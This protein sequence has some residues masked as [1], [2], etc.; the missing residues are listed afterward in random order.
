MSKKFKNL[1]QNIKSNFSNVI[2]F[3]DLIKYVNDR[4]ISDKKIE[5]LKDALYIAK[6][7]L[8][9][10]E[11]LNCIKNDDILIADLNFTR[12]ELRINIGRK[13]D[14]INKIVTQLSNLAHR[15][16]VNVPVYNNMLKML[17][18]SKIN[19][20]DYKHCIIGFNNE[21]ISTI[22]LLDTDKNVL[23]KEMFIK[24]EKDN[25][26]SHFLVSKIIKKYKKTMYDIWASTPF[27]SKGK[28]FT[29][30]PHKKVSDEELE[31]Q[32]NF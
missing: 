13:L 31:I 17:K 29:N 3:N 27:N 21:V 11:K 25:S 26:S 18:Q 19:I 20:N 1:K 16:H 24:N 30:V 9:Y 32:C 22:V 7:D 15:E 10:F 23:V 8:K 12:N 5:I 14:K 28:L 2:I 6:D 4:K